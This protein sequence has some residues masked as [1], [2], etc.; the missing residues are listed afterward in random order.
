MSPGELP[1]G[2]AECFTI[3][4]AGGTGGLAP[5]AAEA[6]IEVSAQVGV[7]G[8]KIPLFEGAHQH[9]PAAGAVVLVAGG[10]ISGTGREAEPA[11]DARVE[12]GKPP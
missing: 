8:R 5:P 7:G 1:P 4:H 9:D 6:G 3:S 2:L 10:E 11:V 12:C